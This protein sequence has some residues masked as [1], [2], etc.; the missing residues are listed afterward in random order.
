MTIPAAYYG[1]PTSAGTWD[2]NAVFNDHPASAILL[3]TLSRNANYLVGA[4]CLKEANLVWYAGTTAVAERPPEFQGYMN[5]GF[6]TENGSVVP[7]MKIPWRSSSQAN[8]LSVSLYYTIYD[9]TRPV[10]IAFGTKTKACFP[11]TQQSYPHYTEATSEAAAWTT[12]VKVPINTSDDDE[13][14]ALY[15]HPVGFTTGSMLPDPH[16]N[17]DTTDSE[18]C[19]FT[20]GTYYLNGFDW[21]FTDQ[22]ISANCSGDIAKGTLNNSYVLCLLDGALDIIETVGLVRGM[23]TPETGKSL[24]MTGTCYSPNPEAAA[25]RVKQVL[26]SGDVHGWVCYPRNGLQI[27]NISIRETNS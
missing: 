6:N 11:G 19:V 7:S 9:D 5:G 16:E 14:L 17:C 23:D 26:A 4:Q 20:V 22:S 24:S 21:E 12:A 18:D 3:R 27:R 1:L 10:Y 15:V 25:E 8:F 13:F 2:E